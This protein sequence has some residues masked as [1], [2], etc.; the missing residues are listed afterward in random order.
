M[1]A[2]YS[3]RFRPQAYRQVFYPPVSGEWKVDDD[4]PEAFFES[5]KVLLEAIINRSLH[6]GFEGVAAMFLCRHYLL[7]S[8]DM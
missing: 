5:A 1:F 8:T 4:F 7:E 2:D 6:E 3:N